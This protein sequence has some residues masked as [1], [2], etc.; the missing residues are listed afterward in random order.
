MLLWPSIAV[1]S[2]LVRVEAMCIENLPHPCGTRG[3]LKREK[4][5]SGGTKSGVE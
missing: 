2:F 4:T 1:P 5:L 3:E